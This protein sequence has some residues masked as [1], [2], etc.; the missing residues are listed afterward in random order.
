MTPVIRDLLNTG[1][2]VLTS[3]KHL[4]HHLRTQ[5]ALAELEAG[6]KTWRSAEILPLDAWIAE[7]WRRL[8]PRDGV[9]RKKGKPAPLLLA[10]LQ[11]RMLW[12]RAIRE[13]DPSPL[14]LLVD[15]MAASARQAWELIHAY[16]I[17]FTEK[18]TAGNE[19]AAAFL[20]WSRTFTR[21]CD[22]RGWVDGARMKKQL[23]DRMAKRESPFAPEA[24][25]AGLLPPCIGIAGFDTLTPID[26]RLID[27]LAARGCEVTEI[28]FP[29][30]PADR[31]ISAAVCRDAEEEVRAAAAWARGLLERQKARR[32]GIV[33][34]D[35]AGRKGIIERIFSEALDPAI[36]LR[37]AA[38]SPAIEFSLGDPLD[39]IPVARA[40]LDMLQ[41]FRGRIPLAEAGN[42]LR[43][44]FL[45]G[46]EPEKERRALLDAELRERNASRLSLDGLASAAAEDPDARWNCPELAALLARAGEPARQSAAALPSIWKERFIA[47]LSAMGWPGDRTPGS[48]EAQAM[49]A[50]GEALDEFAGLDLLGEFLDAEQALATLGRVAAETI[51]QPKQ[52]D[53]PVQ[54]LGV[55]EAAGIAFRH[56]WIMGMND[57]D[58]P[59][60]PRPNP[61]VPLPLQRAC[62]VPD[63]A[64]PARQARYRNMTA[65]LLDSAREIVV[66]HPAAEGDLALEPSAL[67][68]AGIPLLASIESSAPVTC[69]EYFRSR[70][71]DELEIL[72]DDTA[73]PFEAGQPPSGGAKL[74]QLQALCPFRA[75]AE[76]RLNSK[77]V[78]EPVEGLDARRQGIAM[79][80][81]LELFWKKT[82]NQAALLALPPEALTERIRESVRAAIG[83]QRKRSLRDADPLSLEVEEERLNNLLAAWMEVERSRTPFEVLESEEGRIIRA[84]EVEVSTRIDRIDRLAGGALALID[85]K[86]GGAHS[87][88][89]WLGDRPEEP[90]LP[91]YC[92]SDRTL[93]RAAAFALMAPDK[94]EFN[95]ISAEPEMLPSVKT[96]EEATKTKE[97]AG[98]SWGELT[99]RWEEALARLAREHTAGRAAVDPR[100]YPETCRH[101]DQAPLCRI[102]EA[103]P[104]E[105]DAD[106]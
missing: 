102:A 95:G 4:A 79:H 84:G 93:I 103:L 59:P 106:A 56:V 101:C 74:F 64:F 52:D 49:Q 72:T 16:E 83:E 86:S 67:M 38:D 5:Y 75:F 63:A 17:D 13:N 73:P 47:L 3:T 51:F 22:A 1:G 8:V 70:S 53:A 24:A 54:A 81:A 32:I 76:L 78:E 58:W 43:S 44:P 98:I 6:N 30:P 20:R 97:A 94:L 60:Q 40:A 90:Q 50:W 19:D 41:L 61:F 15:E 48:R 65:R 85:Y 2:T 105:K 77:P 34:P 29:A 62:G 10:P 55:L 26:R 71:S 36:A 11:E 9:E 33:L 28:P 92:L 69:A 96:A 18:Y 46:A 37:P 42:I 45:P 88:R 35:L 25:D 82:K 31:R 91:L 89:D 99:A 23:V 104:M 87:F 7:L 57:R 27:A 66:S 14:L 68:P 100:D 12:R 39:G 21:E 80:A